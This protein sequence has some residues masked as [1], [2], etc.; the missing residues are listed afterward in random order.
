MTLKER[1]NSFTTK[2]EALAIH[3]DL[4]GFERPNVTHFSEFLNITRMTYY[5]WPSELDDNRHRTIYGQ[6]I[7]ALNERNA[8]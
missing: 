5:N 2:E 4:F 8:Q 6:L 7:Y 1:I 3:A